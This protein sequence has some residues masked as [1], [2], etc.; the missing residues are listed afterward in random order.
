LQWAAVGE[1]RPNEAYAVTVED[2]TAGSTIVEYVT[3][4]KY[5]LPDEARPADN[6][7]HIFRWS[8]L[9]VRQ[10]GSDQESGKPVWEPAGEVSAQRVFSWFV[11]K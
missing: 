10:I 7:P 6:I 4:T 3:D 1:L 2:V 8:I 9:P 5:I 11:P